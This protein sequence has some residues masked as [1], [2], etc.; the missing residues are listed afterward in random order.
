[1]FY[2]K[3]TDDIGRILIKK[4][5]IRLLTRAKSGRTT[6]WHIVTVITVNNG[7]HELLKYKGTK[8]VT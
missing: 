1:M 5:T 4:M 6:E 3:V 8:S 7:Q 2:L